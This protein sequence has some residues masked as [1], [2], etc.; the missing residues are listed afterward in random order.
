MWRE[1]KAGRFPKPIKIGPRLNAFFEDE[2]DAYLA[3]R[4]AERDAKIAKVSATAARM[5]LGKG[6]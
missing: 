2:I 5:P 1:I 6:A 3:Q 4:A